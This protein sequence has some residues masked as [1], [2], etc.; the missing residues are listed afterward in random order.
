MPL[1]DRV[2]DPGRR[3]RMVDDR[4]GA[5]HEA[6]PRPG[7]R[8]S[9]GST[10]RPSRCPRAAR[11]RSTRGRA[12]CSGRRC[13][14]RS[15]CARA[16]GTDTPPRCGPW[17]SRSRRAP[18][19][20]VR[21]GCSRSVPP[22]SSSASSQRRLAKH[23]QRIGRIH[24]RSRRD[25]GTPGLRISGLV[26]R[27]GWLHVVEAEAALDAQPLVVGEAVAA[28]DAHDAVVLDVVGELA[29]DAAVRADRVAPVLSAGDQIRVVR[30]RQ[31]AGRAGLHAFAAGDAGRLAHRI[32]EVEHDLRMRRRGRRSRSR[33]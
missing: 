3:D 6:R 21:R 17:P 5:D 9:P 7:R 16:S 15:R 31:R 11:R 29:A 32:V 12:A 8:P 24:R 4:I 28:L 27:C 13:W 19:G 20:R 23:R 14:C 30:R 25:F 22:A 1:L 18:W 2:L 10:P 33:R 26:R